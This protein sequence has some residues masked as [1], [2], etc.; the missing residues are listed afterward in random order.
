MIGS[1]HG[2][3]SCI[4]AP[5]LVVAGQHYSIQTVDIHI[6]RLLVA[7]KEARHERNRAL[8][9]MYED[10]LVDLEAER[11]ALLDVPKQR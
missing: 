5:D 1:R 8:A 9:L 4:R 7:L 3:T 11:N 10:E 6:E 2:S